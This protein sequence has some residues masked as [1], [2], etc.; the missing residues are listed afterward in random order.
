MK[1]RRIELEQVRK[2]DGRVVV[3]GIADGLNLVVGAN[4]AGKTTLLAALHAALFLKHGSSRA[5]EQLQHH[6]HRTAPRVVLELE[7][8]GESLHLE[9]QFLQR[10]QAVLRTGDVTLTGDA[11]EQAFQL[12]LCGGGASAG[13]RGLW[14][15]LLVNQGEATDHTVEAGARAILQ[16]SLEAQ[17]ESVTG[18]G[19]AKDIIARLDERLY[20]QRGLIDRRNDRHKGRLRELDQ[21]L[22]EQDD[23]LRDLNERRARLADDIERLGVLLAESDLGAQAQSGHDQEF[24]ALEVKEGHLLH[25]AE[26]TRAALALREA[27]TRRDGRLD[28]IARVDQARKRLE[29][30]ERSV[31]Q[32]VDA[33]DR[34][35]AAGRALARQTE[36][37]DAVLEAAAAWH[38]AAR[39]AEQMRQTAM[40]GATEVAFDLEEAGRGR[41]RLDGSAPTSRR[42]RIRVSRELSLEAEALGRITIRPAGAEGLARALA[43]TQARVTTARARLEELGVAGACDFAGA[44]AFAPGLDRLRDARRD[45]A[46][47]LDAAREAFVEARQQAERAV[48]ERDDARDLGLRLEQELAEARAAAADDT[49]EAAV[50]G[51]GSADPDPVQDLAAGDAAR[52][53]EEV[54]ARL[55]AARHRREAALQQRSDVEKEIAA[56]AGR[57]ATLQ[58]MGLKEEIDER[59]RRR[60]HLEQEIG[61]LEYD[62]AVAKLLRAT[63]I[64]AEQEVRESYT[65]PLVERLQPALDELL[66]GARIKL[67]DNL[68]VT[69]IERSDIGEEP[70]GQ[71]SHGT[72]EQ[73][74]V[75]IRLAFAEVLIDTGQ[76]CFVVLDDAL[77]FSDDDRLERMFRI[78]ERAGRKV[79]ILVLTCRER[80]FQGLA[81]RRLRIEPLGD[82]PEAQDVSARR[83][84]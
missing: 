72:R 13:R 84:A 29:A 52:A 20:G 41:L 55:K 18:G 63:L 73:I 37:E 60:A 76:P 49:L 25:Q 77:V 69:A 16:A 21:S 42:F 83:L 14:H 58:G 53:L 9:K 33:R 68:H 28:L 3:D 2:F 61:T 11:A 82:A 27:R 67:D 26:A 57:I 8:D 70:F 30:L 32:A 45:L 71:L 38:Q 10:P 59:L 7:V 48:R 39:E 40:A 64:S 54:R 6:L 46:R 51:A 65:A 47:K 36:R 22:T 12:R 79:Q 5:R 56:L 81:A 74:A 78:L 19:R 1:L 23:Q 66:P 62:V 75:A 34:A 17:L 50:D 4:E 35:L 80:A 15:L 43:E 44:A 31:G 24:Q